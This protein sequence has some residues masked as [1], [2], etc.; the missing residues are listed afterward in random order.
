[1]KSSSWSPDR[2]ADRLRKRTIGSLRSAFLGQAGCPLITHW[3]SRGTSRQSCASASPCSGS[4][5]WASL[6]HR[7]RKKSIALVDYEIGGL[8]RMEAKPRCKRL[9][10]LYDEVPISLKMRAFFIGLS[11]P[12]APPR[13]VNPQK[14]T[15]RETSRSHRGTGSSRGRR[16]LLR[17][18]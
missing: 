6:R 4:V 17:T 1:M 3:Y 11:C 8:E 14:M 5:R 7:A 10:N 18:Q 13:M 2:R 9:Q 12:Y 16:Y 15:S